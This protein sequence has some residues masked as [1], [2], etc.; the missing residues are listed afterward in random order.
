MITEFF[1]SS[2]EYSKKPVEINRGSGSFWN[3]VDKILYIIDHHLDIENF[4][5]FI[6]KNQHIF[7]ISSATY[8][9][10]STQLKNGP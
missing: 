6:R 2:N 3:Y 9:V 10:L 1:S 8:L 5:T 4:F 7:G